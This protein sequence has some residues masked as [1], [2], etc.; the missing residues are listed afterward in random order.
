MKQYELKTEHGAL[1]ALEMPVPAMTR[2]GEGAETNLCKMM[3]IP[4]MWWGGMGVVAEPVDVGHF[5]DAGG[6]IPNTVLASEESFCLQ[7]FPF[8]TMLKDEKVGQFSDSKEAL[9]REEV[10]DEDNLEKKKKLTI[11]GKLV[12]KAVFYE[13]RS[14]VYHRHS[15]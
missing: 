4:N 7:R 15:E 9:E 3:R 14:L 2:I 12:T 1:T 6:F 13:E 5:G 10:A 11:S 8:S